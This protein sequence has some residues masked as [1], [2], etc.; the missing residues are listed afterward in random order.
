MIERLQAHYGFA[1]MP[2]SRDLAPGML[3]RHPRWRYSCG[4][5]GWPADFAEAGRS[6][7][8]PRRLRP[9]RQCVALAPMQPRRTHPPPRDGAAKLYWPGAL[10]QR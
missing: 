6:H 10:A 4:W 3:H 7:K 9:H 8:T 5:A 1:Q 2:F